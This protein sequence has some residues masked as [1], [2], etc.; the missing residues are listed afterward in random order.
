MDYY[1]KNYKNREGIVDF[2]ITDSVTSKVGNFYEEDPF[3]N[4]KLDDN[5]QT[6]LKIGDQNKIGRA[7]V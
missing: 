5:K 6:I 7:H 1:K 3:P 2:N 4:Y